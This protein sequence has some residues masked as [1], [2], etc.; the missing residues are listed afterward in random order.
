MVPEVVMVQ[1]RFCCF[2][3]MLSVI[4]TLIDT[5]GYKE[6]RGEVNGHVWSRRD[7]YTISDF[8]PKDDDAAC[9]Y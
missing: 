9:F 5:L 7:W 1:H 3:L 8:R 2:N 4:G 6:E